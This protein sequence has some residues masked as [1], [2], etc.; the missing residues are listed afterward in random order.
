MTADI[1]DDRNYDS[2][3][4]I[5]WSYGDSNVIGIL[6]ALV[7]ESPERRE[8]VIRYWDEVLVP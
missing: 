4:A 7:E 3:I 8:E 2:A 5:V 6:R 1:G